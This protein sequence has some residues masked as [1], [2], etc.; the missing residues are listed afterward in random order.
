MSAWP[1]GAGAL[2][3]RAVAVA[4][5]GLAS[6]WAARAA[7]PA[8]RPLREAV[9]VH[10][11]ACLARESL[12]ASVEGWLGRA[13]VDAALAIE[14]EELAD[15]RP[16]FVVSRAGRPAAE[17]TFRA[18]VVPC[19]DLRA[20]VALAIALAIDAAVLEGV[21]EPPPVRA[22]EVPPTPPARAP[23]ARGPRRPVR[24]A[25]ARSRPSPRPPPDRVRR[26]KPLAVA[27]LQGVALL[28]VLPG[29]SWGARV[30][31]LVPAGGLELRAGAL[32][33]AG[34]EPSLGRG[35]V[36]VG[37]AAGEIGGCL[38]SR[39]AGRSLRGCAGAAA[40]EWMASGRGFDVSRSTELPWAAATAGLG[41]ELPVGLGLALS[42]SVS[43]VVPV[44]RP[45]LVVQDPSGSIRWRRPADPA[46]L[47]LGLGL[48]LDLE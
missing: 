30:G 17:R 5:L 23:R 38:V 3:R 41:A 31:A 24:A 46:G 28:G 36:R 7:P 34:A 10:E 19:A 16:R 9:T 15:G 32:L 22:E 13:E 25:G 40:G 43:G 33:G 4:L 6:D 42:G 12:I 1:A 18:G 20:A 26:R 39:A 47:V 37:L 14:V 35:R 44:A 2:G 48:S 45:V 27:D 8:P 29:A 11:G 21:L